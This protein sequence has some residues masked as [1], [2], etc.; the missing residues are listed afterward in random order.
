[1]KNMVL[2][3]LK[4]A[5]VHRIIQNDKLSTLIMSQLLS[6]MNSD[7]MHVSPSEKIDEDDFHSCEM[8]SNT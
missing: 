1:M 6:M 7:K 5:K 2:M 4:W 3:W 8:N